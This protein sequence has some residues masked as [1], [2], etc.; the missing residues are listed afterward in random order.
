MRYLIRRN[1]INASRFLHSTLSE[2]KEKNQRKLKGVDTRQAK[3]QLTRHTAGES[4]PL[5]FTTLVQYFMHAQ[6]RRRHLQRDRRRIW[7]AEKHAGKTTLAIWL[8]VAQKVH[9]NLIERF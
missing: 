8:T 5:S 2:P 4:G 7:S 3:G 9:F 6:Y 1:G